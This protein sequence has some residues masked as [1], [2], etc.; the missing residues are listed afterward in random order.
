MHAVLDRVRAAR[1]DAPLDGDASNVIYSQLHELAEQRFPPARTFCE[2]LLRSV[3]AEW[4]LIAAQ[5]LSHYDLAGSLELLTQ[6]RWMLANDPDSYVRI[7]L[8]GILGAQQADA[9]SWP[10]GAL[11]HT[12]EDDPV[13]QVRS[14]A[15][16]G[17]L[18]TAGIPYALMQRSLQELERGEIKPTWTEIERIVAVAKGSS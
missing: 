9:E 3:D 1:T 10:D 12:I 17:L 18:Q 15:F 8:S 7:W 14:N 11:V 4:R 16:R 5:C 13:L 6:I 2:S